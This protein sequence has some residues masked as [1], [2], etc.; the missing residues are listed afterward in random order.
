[1]TARRA[2]IHDGESGA[3]L[4]LYA[5][6]GVAFATM[7]A[8]VLDI[9]ALRQGRR[10]DRTTA[11]LAATAG[12][13]EL[14]DAVPTAAQAACATAWG[15]ILAN[16]NGEAGSITAPPCP[17]VFP[18][19]APCTSTTTA[20]TATATLGALTVEI[21]N[22]VPDTS[23]LMLAE[24]QGGD[25][26][27]AVDPVADGSQCSRLAVR[28]VRTRTFLFGQLAGVGNASTD[29]HSVGRA[30][31]V[32]SST[33]VGLALLEPVDCGSL[34]VRNSSRLT[35]VATG[36]SKGTI[37]V[38]SNGTGAGCG[39][40]GNYT[41][42]IED[43]ARV[44]GGNGTP[45]LGAILT[46]A[47][48]AGEPAPLKAFGPS[49]V[50]GG[51][52]APVPTAPDRRFGRGPVEQRYDCQP[53]NGCL[54]A[55][56]P[57]ITNLVAAF[58]GPADPAGFTTLATPNCKSSDL[59]PL[60]P[61]GDYFINC[62]PLFEVDT[63]ILFGDGGGATRIVLSASL[64]VK[65]SGCLA[66]QSTNCNIAGSGA[67]GLADN[68]LFV[69]GKVEKE[70]SGLMH[71][72]R[73]MTYVQG[74]ATTKI[75]GNG[76]QFTMTAPDGGDFRDLALWANSGVI[77]LEGQSQLAILGVVYAPVAQLRMKDVPAGSNLQ[78]QAVVDR[79]LVEGPSVVDLRPDPARSVVTSL[80]ATRLIR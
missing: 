3:Y 71:V 67:V 77:E 9:A 16:R 20:R 48:K 45:A 64:Q 29:V 61:G 39:G 41:I 26:A 22:P 55:P 2:R 23:S 63:P 4:V 68:V 52:L 56:A 49:D 80:R 18:A 11:D 28:I 65:S 15:Y 58:G 54:A 24:A 78:V 33:V 73:T 43:S 75:L 5:L 42:R 47:L 38:D 7:A 66:I 31:V 60:L 69:R 32:P 70:S 6:L 79:I 12:V 72:A 51:E 37:A 13:A 8:V 40:G 76:G 50:A 25:V 74:A 57:A 62:G 35:V 46:Y 36:S 34:H 14:H 27:Q 30:A 1:M 59:P 53:S 10:V 17:T 21:T 19:G 44:R